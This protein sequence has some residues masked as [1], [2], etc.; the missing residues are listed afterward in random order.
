MRSS[1]PKSGEQLVDEVQRG[2]TAAPFGGVHVAVDDQRR[3]VGGGAGGA[4]GQREEPEVAPF[5]RLADALERDEIR[6]RRRPRLQERR[7]LLVA[8][9]VVER[10]GGKRGSRRPGRRRP[11]ARET[12]TSRAAGR[13]SG[14]G[15]APATGSACSFLPRLSLRFRAPGGE[16]A[17]RLFE[18]RSHAL[19]G[20]PQLIGRERREAEHEPGRGRLDRVAREWRDVEAGVRQAR[21]TRRRRRRRRQERPIEVHA[22]VGVRELERQ[23][24]RRRTA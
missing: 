15:P 11:S 2:D 9:D 19:K 23:L 14:P 8:Q 5:G 7:Q 3:F 12:S 1:L 17:R 21:A 4:R 10:Q 24:R 22:A 20:R 16:L 13:G 18:N 6:A